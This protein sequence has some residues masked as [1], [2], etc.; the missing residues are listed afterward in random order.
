MTKLP[1]QGTPC[2]PLAVLLGAAVSALLWIALAGLWTLL[3]TLTN[4]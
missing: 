4:G 3:V 2:L 1:P